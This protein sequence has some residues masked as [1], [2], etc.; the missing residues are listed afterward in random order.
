MHCVTSRTSKNPTFSHPHLCMHHH[1]QHHPCSTP[2]L[3]SSTGQRHG[4]PS[5]LIL[6]DPRRVPPGHPLPPPGPPRP[7]LRHLPRPHP[8]KT[9]PPRVR[10]R[11][12]PPHWPRPLPR[13][14]LDGGGRPNGEKTAGRSPRPPQNPIHFLDHTTV[15]DLWN[16]RDVHS[17][18][19][20]RVLLQTIT[21][22]QGHASVPHGNNILFLFIWVLFELVVGLFGEQDHI[23]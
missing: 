13:H 5:H 4:H 16:F 19:I 2:D 9:H 20:N 10:H 7:P 22:S 1:L 12:P 8:P 3:L 14:L 18:W 15:L 21:I 17:R 11:P 6:P 23:F